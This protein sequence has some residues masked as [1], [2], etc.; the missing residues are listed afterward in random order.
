MSVTSGEG[1]GLSM[2]QKNIREDYVHLSKNGGARIMS[3][4]QKH[5]GPQIMSPYTKMSRGVLGDFVLHLHKSL[6]AKCN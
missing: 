4:L 6:K 1:L 5:E 3:I 2:L